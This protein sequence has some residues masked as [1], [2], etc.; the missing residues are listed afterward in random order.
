MLYRCPRAIE[1]DEAR[2]SF[3]VHGLATI[4]ARCPRVPPLEL[5]AT[6]IVILIPQTFQV[7]NGDKDLNYL[8]P[9]SVTSLFYSIF[10]LKFT[11]MGRF[12][13]LL[14]VRL[15]C[16]LTLLR[17]NR[18]LCSQN[19]GVAARDYV[20]IVAMSTDGYLFLSRVMVSYGFSILHFVYDK[21]LVIRNMNNSKKSLRTYTSWIRDLKVGVFNY[22]PITFVRGSHVCKTSATSDICI[23]FYSLQDH[24]TPTL[25]PHEKR[26]RVSDPS[27]C[28]FRGK[29]CYMG[30]TKA[31]SSFPSKLVIP[32]DFNIY[33]R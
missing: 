19:Q 5:L 2:P 18:E 14:H 26:M 28:D 24:Y 4:F 1:H 6:S 17:L 12:M 22:K 33:L 3:D 27:S 11:S 8:H 29:T 10:L 16:R 32:Y 30:P 31:T 20:L 15:R 9:R 25:G 13:I 23:G 21:I 7:L